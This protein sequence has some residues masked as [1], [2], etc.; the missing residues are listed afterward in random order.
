MFAGPQLVLVFY[1]ADRSPVCTDELALFNELLPEFE[2]YK[3]RVVAISCDS[4]WCHAALARDL[5]GH[6][7]LAH[8]RPPGRERRIG[9]V[10]PTFFQVSHGN[11]DP[12]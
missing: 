1:P 11:P 3:A 10:L 8:R 5:A 12:P 7:P 4:A 6:R 2:R 9:R